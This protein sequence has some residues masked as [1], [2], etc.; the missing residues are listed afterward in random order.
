MVV[1][2]IARLSW[3]AESH[4][5]ELVPQMEVGWDARLR[6]SH[7]LGP[8][9]ARA[10][11]CHFARFL[12]SQIRAMGR[13][14]SRL[15]HD[16]YPRMLGLTRASDDRNHRHHIT[17]PIASTVTYRPATSEPTFSSTTLSGHKMGAWG[18]GAHGQRHR[19]TYS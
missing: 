8:L 2:V 14:R 3:V 13:P 5:V 6:K 12:F 16:P 18:L 10:T 19:C 9:A 1:H 15:C 17:T 7:T 11:E 4:P